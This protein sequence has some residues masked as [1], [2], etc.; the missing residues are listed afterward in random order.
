MFKPG[1][2]IIYAGLPGELVNGEAYMVMEAGEETVTLYNHGTH[3]NKN[4]YQ[5]RD[6]NGNDESTPTRHFDQ[7]AGEFI[8]PSDRQVLN[9]RGVY[10]LCTEDRIQNVLISDIG[11][12]GWDLPARMRGIDCICCGGSR[13]ITA[14]M[15]LPV[16]LIEGLPDEKLGRRY[17]QMDGKHRTAKRIFFGLTH[18]PAYVFHIDEILPYIN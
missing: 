1:D 15:D 5:L 3:L 8:L 14:D 18:S 13:M 7:I 10:P 6:F 17:R 4:F 11:G 9:L 12:I 2:C 16:F